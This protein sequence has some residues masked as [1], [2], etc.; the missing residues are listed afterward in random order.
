MRKIREILRLALGEGLSRRR[1]GAATRLPY[2]TIADHL[3]RAQRAG[4]GW[5]LPDDMDDAQLEARLFAKPEPPPSASRPLPD[6]PTVQREMRRKGMTLQLLHMEF[7][8]SHPD[9]YQYTQF[10]RHYRAWQRR[11]DVVMR[12]EHRAGEKLFVDFAGQTIP[13]VDPA[14]GEITEAQLFVAVL[15]ASSY[16]YAEALP[17]QEL[18]HWISAHVHAFSWF[19]GCTAIVVPDNLRSAVSRAHLYEPELNRT[20]EEMAAH[21]GCAV[22]PGRPRKPRDKAKAESGVLV[23]ERWILAVLRHRTFF[24]LAEA[25][26]AIRE[27][28]AWLNARPFRKLPGSRLSLFEEL[29]RPALRPLPA[30]PYEFATW[31]KATVNVD[32]HV[33]VDR[34][35]YS[36]PHQLVGEECDIRVTAGVVEVL[37]KR[38]RVASHPRSHV[39]RHFSTDAAHMPEAHRR[40]AEWTPGRIVA[41]AE[42]TGPSTADL[43]AAIMASR[44]H[45]EQGFRS[46]LGIMRLGRRHGDERLEA[47]AARALAIGAHSYRSV[48]SILKSGLDRQPLPGSEPVTTSIGDH[49]N[50]RGAGYYE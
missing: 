5:P 7:K 13:I 10:C 18:P 16:T 31:K 8:E 25:N 2:T 27:R 43:V 42:R 45:P 24:S 19:E 50:V 32:Y 41:W 3:G 30:L 36:V 38:R 48:E 46:C 6:W 17:S 34:H 11:V 1:V 23:A 40:H 26:A 47:A 29:D 33:E 35:W 49:A 21:Y 4:L 39:Q 28:L 22:I 20:Y 9:G 14:T 37:H 12:Q 44:P 15:G